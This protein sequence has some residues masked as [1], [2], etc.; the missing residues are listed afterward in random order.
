M[1]DKPAPRDVVRADR[2]V[3]VSWN[4][5]VGAGNVDRL[6]AGLRT[7]EFTGGDKVDEFV[8]LL[9]EAYRAD[10]AIPARLARGMPAPSR[11][12][13]AHRGPS[14][15]HWWRADGLAVFYAPSMRNGLI[16]LNRE[17]RGNAIVST[18]PLEDPAAIELPL[19]RQRRVAI[20]ASVSG[21]SRRGVRWRVRLADVHLDTAL[22]LFS[23][24][25]FA[26]RARQAEALVDALAA[27]HTQ[28]PSTT[29]VAGDFN[30]WGGRERALD[31][32][33]RAFPDAQPVDGATWR[34]PLGIH[35][36]L[37]HLFAGGGRRVSVRRLPDRLGSDHY[38]LIAIVTF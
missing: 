13:E 22:A 2:L 6:V 35:A 4:L 32:V 34:G 24:G 8:L 3:I 30:T 18:L 9:Q 25:P 15:D 10:D 5:H 20:T 33:A 14:I 26:A 29:I 12:A 31:L 37:D 16:D 1:R 27:T 21:E 11:I 36:T 38:P 28:P 19:E 23:G 17:D 7:G